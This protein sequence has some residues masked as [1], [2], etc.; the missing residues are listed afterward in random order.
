[1]S[2]DLPNVRSLL[3]QF[4]LVVGTVWLGVLLPN[5][6]YAGCYYGSPEPHLSEAE[7]NQR[8]VT[9]FGTFSTR[10]QVSVV[11]EYGE[12]KYFPISH[13]LLPCRGPQ[14]K[15]IPLSTMTVQVDLVR[16]NSNQTALTSSSF[17]V[18]PTKTVRFLNC[19]TPNT[20]VGV[21]RG[22]FRP[23]RSC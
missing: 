5:A 13:A 18:A 19:P 16:Q 20:C 4:C 15:K 9:V 12:F 1:M 22:I 14:C 10:G 21:D 7:K 6:A 17:N 2:L 23:P 11:Y 8:V 3:Q